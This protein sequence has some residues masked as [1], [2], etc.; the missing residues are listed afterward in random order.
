MGVPPVDEDDRATTRNVQQTMPDQVRNDFPAVVAYFDAHAMKTRTGRG[1]D[2][3]DIA[4]RVDRRLSGHGIVDVE[5]R[6]ATELRGDTEIGDELDFFARAGEHIVVHSPDEPTETWISAPALECPTEG[7]CGCIQQRPRRFSRKLPGEPRNRSEDALAHVLVLRLVHGRQYRTLTSG[8]RSRP[9][10]RADCD[11]S[12][13]DR[14]R[15]RRRTRLR[16]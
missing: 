16:W 2:H 4:R 3:A 10:G 13:R 1:N 5:A 11:T 6:D 12:A 9:R 15:I 7:A 14:A 8:R